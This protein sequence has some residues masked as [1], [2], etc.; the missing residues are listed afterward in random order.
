MNKIETIQKNIENLKL[1]LASIKGDVTSFEEN[2]YNK[3]NA[4][5]LKLEEIYKELC[6]SKTETEAEAETKNKSGGCCDK[7]HC[8]DTKYNEKEKDLNFEM[9]LDSIVNDI[10]RTYIKEDE[11]TKE[12]KSFKEKPSKKYNKQDNKQNNQQD[13]YKK[14]DLYNSAK[15]ENLYNIIIESL[16]DDQLF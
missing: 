12:E 7:C 6:L 13:F 16:F 8:N 9:I 3:I 15:K 10:L 1:E 4:S 11:E 5:M 2:I 14:E